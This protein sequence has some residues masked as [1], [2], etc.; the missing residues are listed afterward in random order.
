[1]PSGSLNNVPD[2][3]EAVYVDPDLRERLRA[4]VM[5]D[6]ESGDRAR[7]HWDDIEFTARDGKKRIVSAMN[8]PLPEQNLMIFRAVQD[9]TAQFEAQNALRV[10][11]EQFRGLVEQAIAGIYIIQDGRLVY[12]NQRCAEIFGY[13][14]ADALTGLD[15]LATGG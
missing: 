3:F 12:V 14:K 1:M 5:A 9:V 7:M 13:A 15:P 8:I 4:R 6:I 11:E 2:F 10:A